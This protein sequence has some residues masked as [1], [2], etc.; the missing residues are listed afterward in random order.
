MSTWGVVQI[1]RWAK[2]AH[3]T[4]AQL[5]TAVA[6]AMAYSGG[7]DHTVTNPAHVPA[8]ERRGLWGLTEAEAGPDYWPYL[9]DPTKA[10]QAAHRAWEEHGGSWAWHPVW[11]SGAALRELPA[12]RAVL[13][14]PGSG[15]ETAQVTSFA[16]RLDEHARLRD[17]MAQQAR[18]LGG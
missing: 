5:D 14:A 18:R 4:G 11:A 12:V 8:L 1:A 17:A 15:S 7:N 6:V 2:E 9:F 16:R 13:D 10:A 3:W